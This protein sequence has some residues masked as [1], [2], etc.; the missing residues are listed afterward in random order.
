M[1]TGTVHSSSYQIASY[2]KRKTGTIKKR[3]VIQIRTCRS[4]THNVHTQK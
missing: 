3:L 1:E 4:Q 2:I